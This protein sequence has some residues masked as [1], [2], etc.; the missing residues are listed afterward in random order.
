[1]RCLIFHGFE[2]VDEKSNI[3]CADHWA[4]IRPHEAEI[5]KKRYDLKSEALK[6]IDDTIKE[7]GK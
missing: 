7:D 5:L 1:M 4:P 2:I 6:V 3:F